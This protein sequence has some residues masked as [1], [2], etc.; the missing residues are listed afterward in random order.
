MKKT[1]LMAIAAVLIWTGC[2]EEDALNSSRQGLSS[3]SAVIEQNSG[4]S[5]VQVNENDEGGATLLCVTDDAFNTFG[6]ITAEYKYNGSVFNVVGDI[7]QTIN[8]AVY[9]SSYQ[10]SS[11]VRH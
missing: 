9:P 10:P 1:L 11:M 3:I 2:S 7:P 5:R 8:Y 4:N 6:N